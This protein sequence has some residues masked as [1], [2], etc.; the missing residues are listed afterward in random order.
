[1]NLAVEAGTSAHLLARE[2]KLPS[3]ATCGAA[4]ARVRSTNTEPAAAGGISLRLFLLVSG[5]HPRSFSC[6]ESPASHD[7]SCPSTHG[8]VSS[9]PAECRAT[10]RA[11]LGQECPRDLLLLVLWV[12]RLHTAR[13]DILAVCPSI[14]I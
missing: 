12:W 3:L 14:M 13:A 5:S 8:S 11:S 9:L 1:M 6:C 10:P 7:P 4:A 2:T